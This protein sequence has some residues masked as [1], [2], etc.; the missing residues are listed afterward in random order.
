MSDNDINK[1]KE[2]ILKNSDLQIIIFNF[3]RGTNNKLPA[4]RQ[5]QFIIDKENYNRSRYL[6]DEFFKC[7]NNEDF[8]E[9][10]NKWIWIYHD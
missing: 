10:R 3:E 7:Q 8:E 4:L 5:F 9:F 6:M 2:T 1:I